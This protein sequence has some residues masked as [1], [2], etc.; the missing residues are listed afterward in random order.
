MEAPALKRQ[1]DGAGTLVCS[2][3]ASIDLPPGLVV[4]G[5]RTSLNAVIDYAVPSAAG[6][7]GQAVRLAGAD[8]ITVPLATLSRASDSAAQ[9][10]STTDQANEAEPRSLN[11]P[12]V[13]PTAPSPQPVAPAPQPIPVPRAVT[14]PPAPTP[15][16]ASSSPAFNCRYAR[17]RGEVGVCNDDGLASLDR[18]MTGVY[19]EALRAANPE[20]YALLHRT[21]DRFLGYRDRCANTACM[22]AAYRD[23]IREV[24]DI[25]AA[26]WQPWG[27]RAA[28]GLARRT[29]E[30]G[31]DDW[32]GMCG[33]AGVF[34]SGQPHTRLLRAMVDSLRYR[35]SDASGIWP[36]AAFEIG[37][38]YRRL[39]IF[40]L[41]SIAPSR[42]RPNQLLQWW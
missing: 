12:E 23:R 26:R 37:F 17:T 34:T 28:A 31:E 22:A 16:R 24:R 27:L 11:T 41:S 40:D 36:E 8:P 35:G 30:I 9:D 42:W 13:G 20:Q 18:R 3:R 7:S 19:V 33:I 4:A 21:R 25:M 10:N 39:A 1:D 38:S 5:G 2:G 6:G 15:P 14:P 32:T 29:A